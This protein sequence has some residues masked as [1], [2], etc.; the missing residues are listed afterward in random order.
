MYKKNQINRACAFVFTILIVFP[1]ASEDLNAVSNQQPTYDELRFT[2][3]RVG[4]I[5]G[6][7]TSNSESG[8]LYTDGSFDLILYGRPGSL[9]SI[10]IGPD[11]KHPTL[12]F[13]SGR[14]SEAGE[15]IITIRVPDGIEDNM[16]EL[17]FFLLVE[18]PSYV[19]LSV[20]STEPSYADESA[21]CLEEFDENI[22][23]IYDIDKKKSK[24]GAV[25]TLK[26]RRIEP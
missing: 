17:S 23:P 3:S 26:P 14:I 11:P 21:G 13:T 25:R 4:P 16:P 7:T 22:I 12:L 5:Y 15:V 1:L 18:S 2:W 9:Y 10:F 19:L 6:D 20:S 8:F 24:V